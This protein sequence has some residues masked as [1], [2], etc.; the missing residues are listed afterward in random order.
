MACTGGHAHHLL[1]HLG[2]IGI[3]EAE[4]TVTSLFDGADQATRLELGEMGTCR[5][6][7]DTGFVGEFACCQ[8]FAAHQ[9]RQHV[10]ARGI[11]CQRGDRCNRR[12]CFHT[13]TLAEA[14]VPAQR[15]FCFN[16]SMETEA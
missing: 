1:Q 6:R 8:R 2:N 4:V 14:F 16:T 3:G 12:T 5:L 9:S 13:S 11:A 10:R 7:R 15:L